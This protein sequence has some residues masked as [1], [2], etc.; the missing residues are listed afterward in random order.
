MKRLTVKRPSRC[1]FGRALFS[2]VPLLMCLPFLMGSPAH[3]FAAQPK[4]SA[5]EGKP[6]EIAQLAGIEALADAEV[7]K[8]PGFFPDAFR[9]DALQGRMNA[10]VEP[11]R[12]GALTPEPG[13][14]VIL[15]AS[16]IPEASLRALALDAGRLGIPLALSGLPVKARTPQAIAAAQKRGDVKKSSPFVI[17]REAVARLSRLLNDAGAAAGSS[18][19]VWHAVR[20]SLP[21]EPAVPALVLFGETAIEVFPG[22]MRPLRALL[23]ASARARTPEIRSLASERL[24]RAGLFDEA[25]RLFE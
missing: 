17:D 11:R 14:I 9:D 6:P 8:A 3:A 21:E 20:D 18:P 25:R 10:A 5:G 2:A 24:K 7:L 4:R 1:V 13:S 19:A 15:A 16:S 22:D 23:L 12:D